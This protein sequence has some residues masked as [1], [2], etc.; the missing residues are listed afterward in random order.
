MAAAV[1][2]GALF[3]ERYGGVFHLEEWKYKTAL[4]AYNEEEKIAYVIGLASDYPD[5]DL[6]KLNSKDE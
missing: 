5:L 6:D 2:T 3:T 4:V 1:N